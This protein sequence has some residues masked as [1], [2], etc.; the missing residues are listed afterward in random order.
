MITIENLTKEY[1]NG[2]KVLDALCLNVD[3][4]E[5]IGFVGSNGAGKTTALRILATL[6]VPTSGRVTI[7]GENSVEKAN[8]VR[9]IIGYVSERIGFYKNFKAIWNLKFY[10]S[11]FGIN[12]YDRINYYTPLIE[13]MALTEHLHVP[14]GKFSKGMTQKLALVRALLHDPPILILDEPLNGLDVTSR[15]EFKS[16]LKELA[17][18][19]KTIVLSTHVLKDVDDVCSRLIIIEK[20][21]KLFD[22]NMDIVQR[23]LALAED[24]IDLEEFYLKIRGMKNE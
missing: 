19:G 4:G 24:K 1:E 23:N 22:K 3:H 6:L 21:K 12:F 20:G 14:V 18:K 8:S 17:A 16:L 11:C 10:A 15:I 5:I 13:R 7:C 9:G 2:I